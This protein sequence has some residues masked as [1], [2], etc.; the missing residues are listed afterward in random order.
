MRGFASSLGSRGWYEVDNF[1]FSWSLC[2]PSGRA[3]KTGYAGDDWSDD[4]FARKVEQAAARH[5]RSRPHAARVVAG[6][7]RTYLAPAALGN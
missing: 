5:A 3:I 6:H 4:V 1:N 7:Y 2:D